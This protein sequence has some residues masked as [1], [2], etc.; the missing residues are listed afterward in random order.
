MH[1]LAILCSVLAMGCATVRQRNLCEA[2]GMEHVGA[3]DLPRDCHPC[4]SDADCRMN[5]MYVGKFCS[6]NNPPKRCLTAPSCSSDAQCQNEGLVCD[7][8]AGSDSNGKCV[9]GATCTPGGSF[10]IPSTSSLCHGTSW[11][12]IALNVWSKPSAAGAP[13]A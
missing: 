7:L 9:N 12:W 2:D 3:G 1:W 5:G 6:I 13:V 10:R 4:Q 11:S 8:Q